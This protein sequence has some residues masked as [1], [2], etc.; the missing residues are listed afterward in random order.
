MENLI[1]SLNVVLPLFFT[2][3]LGYV[4]K[5]LKMFDDN[6]LKV[7]NSITFKAFL[8]L[9]LFYNIYKTDL[10]GAINLKLILFAL[11]S[12]TLTF[13]ILCIIIPLIEKNNQKRGVLIQG[14]F[15]SNF[16]IFGLPVACSLFSDDKV[17]VVAILIATVVPLF[18]MLAV[19]ALEIFRC[20]KLDIK[21]TLKGIIT[22][23]L[24][25]A[26]AIGLSFLSLGIKLPTAI[27]KSVSDISRIATPLSL[28]LLGGSFAFT[29]VKTHLKQT[30]IGVTGRL[31]II[32]GI[33]MPI[34]IWLGFRDVELLA[35]MLIFASPTAISS[36]TMAQKMDAD[37]DLAAQIV[38]FTS[39]F[40][41]L[42]VFL[43]IFLL[44]QFSLI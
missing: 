13:V 8:P 3:A 37:S 43:W 11:I 12:V 20:G 34:S 22:N 19:I 15:R 24:I 32:P 27:E 5:R 40:C 39:A 2:M 4:L 14:I 36:F 31:I 26:S 17:G 28:I 25:I 30:V 23:P 35:L 42:T 33:L 44:K 16:V 9:L 41:I 7:M 38:V 10:N 21:N 29:D 18:N 6:T 1:L